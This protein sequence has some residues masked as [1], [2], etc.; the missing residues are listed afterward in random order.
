MIAF[1]YFVVFELLGPL[2]ELGGYLAVPAATALGVVSIGFLLAFF[3]LAVLVGVVL[4]VAALALEEFG[5]RRHARGR[6]VG[7][8]IVFAFLENLGYRQF[9]GLVRA[10][11]FLDLARRR[12]GW[13]EMRRRGLGYASLDPAAGRR[14]R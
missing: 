7:R 14:G 2:I 3:A 11:A 4:S 5:F 9:I 8:M 13:G 1:P 12:R 10:L 6:D